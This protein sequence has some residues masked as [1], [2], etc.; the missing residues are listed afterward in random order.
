MN[1]EQC[2]KA[3]GAALARA[4]ARRDSL[5]PREAA[6]EAWT[7]GGPTVDELEARIIAQRLPA[8]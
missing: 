5:P 3:A 7:P 4:R 8:A 2:I 1:R 6:E